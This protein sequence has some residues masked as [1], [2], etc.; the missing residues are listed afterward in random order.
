MVKF[1]VNYY[2]PLLEKD[3]EQTADEGFILPSS[4]NQGQIADVFY[5][6]GSVCIMFGNPGAF[7]YGL[8]LLKD[9]KWIQLSLYELESVLNFYNLLILLNFACAYLVKLNDLLTNEEA[10][11]RRLEEVFRLISFIV[12]RTDGGSWEN[13]NPEKKTVQKPM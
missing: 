12:R 2:Q 8:R 7:N 9:H 11:A 6:V 10:K 3:E 4:S 1:V 13:K 5:L